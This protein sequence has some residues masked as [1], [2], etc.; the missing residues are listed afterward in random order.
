MLVKEYDNP[1]GEVKMVYHMILRRSTDKIFFTMMI[2]GLILANKKNVPLLAPPRD[3]RQG[4]IPYRDLRC[5]FTH[6]DFR[7]EC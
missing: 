3:L 7:L 6:M 2:I 5:K 4:Q 1:E